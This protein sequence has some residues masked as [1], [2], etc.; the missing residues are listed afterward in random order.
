[1]SDE[2]SSLEML[3]A[4]A[5]D[6]LATYFVFEY[7]RE[8]IFK[9]TGWN[10]FVLNFFYLLNVYIGY[11]LHSFESR[12]HLQYFDNPLLI[13]YWIDMLVLIQWDW[14]RDKH[15]QVIFYFLLLQKKSTTWF[16]L[17]IRKESCQISQINHGENKKER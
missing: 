2:F 11:H 12:S 15:E 17:L 7:Y 8:Y 1:M 3:S 16:S 10:I 4:F 5:S 13:F 14:P 6:T 9:K